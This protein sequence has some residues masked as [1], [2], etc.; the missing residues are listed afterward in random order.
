LLSV[1]HRAL[2]LS[3]FGP[4]PAMAL[5]AVAK[6]EVAKYQVAKYQVAKVCVP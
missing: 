6:D 3:I 2:V 1:D 5:A 4:R